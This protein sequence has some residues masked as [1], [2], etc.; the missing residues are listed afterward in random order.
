MYDPTTTTPPGD[1]S[2]QNEGCDSYHATDGE[3]QWYHI[4]LFG[5]GCYGPL[6]ASAQAGT[7][8]CLEDL[9]EQCQDHDGVQE[10]VDLVEERC[11]PCVDDGQEEAGDVDIGDLNIEVFCIDCDDPPDDFEHPVPDGGGHII[12]YPDND[13]STI[14]ICMDS[15]NYDPCTILAHELTHHSQYC[16]IGLCDDDSEDFWDLFR[17]DCNRLCREIEA[18]EVHGGC[19]NH[20]D[21]QCCELICEAYDIFECDDDCEDFCEDADECCSGGVYSC[22]NELCE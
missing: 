16:G 2:T 1:F 22:D 3:D 11:E 6:G 17:N 14:V 7:D 8:D 5:L 10:A 21:Q 9:L 4:E 12:P 20:S 19:D 13:S 15:E 18:W